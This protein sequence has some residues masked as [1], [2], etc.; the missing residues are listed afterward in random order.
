MFNRNKMTDLTAELKERILKFKD[1]TRVKVRF[2]D[3]DAMGVVHFQ[4][5]LVYFDDGFVS[6]MNHISHPKRIEDSVKDGIVCGVKKVNITYEGSARFGDHVLVET[7]IK[8]IGK[9]SITYH[10]KICKEAD[11][12]I[13]A[14][15]DCT[16][17]FMD[18]KTN[19]LIDVEKF[20]LDYTKLDDS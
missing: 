14:Q 7:Q 16:R 11:K 1:V 19:E 17:F 6:F 3:T 18:M 15:V 12:T 8:E 4:N 5:Y 9:K 13:L 20:L 10:H 2:N